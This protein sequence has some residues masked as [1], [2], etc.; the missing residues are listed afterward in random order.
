MVVNHDAFQ[1]APVTN[2]CSTTDERS[3]DLSVVS[4]VC[5]LKEC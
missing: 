1:L 5:A 2:R 4:N 3:D